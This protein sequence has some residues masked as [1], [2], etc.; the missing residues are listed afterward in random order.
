[1]TPQGNQANHGNKI[2][3]APVES[4]LNY[5]LKLPVQG[6]F[7]HRAPRILMLLKIFPKILP[8]KEV[9]AQSPKALIKAHL[10]HLPHLF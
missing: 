6:K 10:L 8:L 1:M 5:P 4:F 3:Q 2:H 7:P 9:R